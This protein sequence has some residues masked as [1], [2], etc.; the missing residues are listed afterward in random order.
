MTNIRYEIRAG[1]HAPCELVSITKIPVTT[2]PNGL[3]WGGGEAV[4]FVAEGTHTQC[5]RILAALSGAGTG[6]GTHL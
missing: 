4:N 6:D 3:K 2:L 1:R 5:Q